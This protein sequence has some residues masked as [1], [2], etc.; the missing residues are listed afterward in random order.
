MHSHWT[1][2]RYTLV[3]MWRE[4]LNV[5]SHLAASAFVYNACVDD[6]YSHNKILRATNYKPGTTRILTGFPHSAFMQT[7]AK[8]HKNAADIMCCIT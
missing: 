1:R 6:L 5:I 8:I 2:Y 7:L 4:K 3:K